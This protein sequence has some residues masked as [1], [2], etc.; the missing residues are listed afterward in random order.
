MVGIM[1]RAFTLIEL[2]IVLVIIGLLLAG[3]VHHT[4]HREP[5]K[6]EQHK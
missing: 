5:V 4:S 1:R 3:I 6:Q 2:P